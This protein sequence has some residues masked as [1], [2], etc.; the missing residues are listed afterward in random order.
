MLAR[1]LLAAACLAVS[2]TASAA[3]A[4]VT[5]GTA[6]DPATQAY[7]ESD[8]AGDTM[9]LTCTA[10]QVRYMALNLMPCANVHDLFITGNGGNDA[11]DLSSLTRADFPNL[12]RVLIRMGDGIDTVKGTQMADTIEG[13]SSDTVSGFDGDDDVTNGDIVNGGLGDDTLR[14]VSGAIDAGPGDD[15]IIQPSGGGNIGGGTGADTLT[16][17]FRTAPVSFTMTLT[18]DGLDLVIPSPPTSAHIPWSSLER[19]SVKLGDAA[20]TLDASRFSGDTDLRAGPGDDHVIAAKGDNF[21]YGE[22]GNDVLDGGSGFDYA[23]GGIGDDTFHLRD[24]G[25][26]RARCGAG[27]D[28]V[29]ADASDSLD[30]CETVILPAPPVAP[31]V[32]A[33]PGPLAVLDVVASKL[34]FKTASLTGRRLTFTATC[35]KGETRCK[36]TATL[37]VTGRR[38]A[39]DST[40]TLGT[41][42]VS[43]AGGQTTT[44]TKT[45]TAIKLKALRRLKRTSLKVGLTVSDDAGNRVTQSAVLGVKVPKS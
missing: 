15:T 38:G 2:G 16:Y 12:T 41:A 23:D 43:V 45:I 27:S 7:L 20:Q 34:S 11:V 17:D 44:L 8:G 14:T 40:V 35:P 21:L 6:G 1:V 39:K 29:T 33:A 10:G 36:G 9:A 25:S 32:P 26:D 31:A 28:T 4:A 42:N 24:G 19:L 3:D 5:P 30:G 13:D 37:K 18:D 22:G